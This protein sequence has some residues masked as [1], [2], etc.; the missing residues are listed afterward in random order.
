GEERRAANGA[1]RLEYR[2]GSRRVVVDG[3]L[4]D[5]HYV[6]PPSDI[7]K[8]GTIL[9]IDRETTLRTSA[10][11]D[12]KIGKLQVQA[13]G[14]AHSLDR[15]SRTFTDA[16]LA[17]QVQYEELS[18]QRYGGTALATQPFAK[19]WR[20]AASAT[21]DHERADVSTMTATTTGDA[22][23]I[24]AALDVQYE[25]K[26]VR[27]DAAGGVAVPQGVGAD[28]W[29]E[30]KLAAKV[31]P[32]SHLELTAT[33]GYKGR[34]PSL[35]ERFGSVNGNP[36]LGPEQALHA[37]LRA[38]EQYGG[39]R[40]EVAPFYRQ[41]TGTVRASADAADMGKL[42]NLG[43]LDIYGI[44]VQGKLGILD[45]LE[46]GGSYNYIRAKSDVSDDPL[47]RLPHHRADGWISVSPLAR[48]TA[49]ARARFTGEAIDKALPTDSYFLVEG[50]LTA[51]ITKEYLGVLKVDDALDVRPET[52]AGFHMPGRTITVVFQG[53]WE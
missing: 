19:D 36:S 18:A 33:T 13:Q 20:W 32:L 34:V 15:R 49:L 16:A 41:T 51:R 8:G 38:V 31:K 30:A 42:V 4:D 35:R 21:V 44:D 46:V 24:N 50:T 5:R 3:F 27:I 7:N 22:T 47:D 43:E 29:P 23:M 52:R 6:A 48:V 12:D 9:L 37:E 11:A 40:L 26:R 25:R 2:R 28:P 1:A 17:S 39:A 53:T 45:T 14:W 10:K